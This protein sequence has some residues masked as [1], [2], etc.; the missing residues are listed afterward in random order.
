MREETADAEAARALSHLLCERLWAILES[1]RDPYPTPEWGS[2]DMSQYFLLYALSKDPSKTVAE[3]DVNIQHEP[4]NHSLASTVIFYRRHMKPMLV[5]RRF[6]GEQQ[7]Q[8]GRD[9]PDFLGEIEEA[10][11]L[12]R[13]G[14]TAGP[15]VCARGPRVRWWDF[16]RVSP[17][18]VLFALMDQLAEEERVSSS[19]SASVLDDASMPRQSALQDRFKVYNSNNLKPTCLTQ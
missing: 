11:G 2:W 19:Y 8:R 13:G 1:F 5:D 7:Y 6:C 3:P 15:T 10:L 16:C 17:S 4:L 9:G 18:L 14:N 12:P